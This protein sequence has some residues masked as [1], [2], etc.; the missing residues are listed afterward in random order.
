MT[1]KPN[2]H[3]E[4]FEKLGPD[5]RVQWEITQ[6]ESYRRDFWIIVIF[7][8]VVLLL[9]ALSLLAPNSFWKANEL[10]LRIPPQ[11]LFV[12]MMAMVVLALYFLRRETESRKLRLANLKRTIEHNTA[13]TA[14]LL[15]SLTNVF[16]RN[17]LYELLQGEIARAE[18]NQRPLTLVMCDVNNFK[19][20]NDR[21]GHLMGDYVLAQIAAILKYCIRGSDYVVRYGGDEFLIIL[22]ET[23]EAGAR[24][25]VNRIREK[26]A[27][28][29]NQSR[30]G[31]MPISVSL[32]LSTHVA[33][34][35]AEKDLAEAD[36]RMYQSKQASRATEPL[37][38]AP[39]A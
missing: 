1:G 28:W 24:I 34:Y 21:Y 13:H 3:H 39:S 2:E 36:S 6:I 11:V 33:G 16:N 31:D 7:V 25:V 9:G 29:D 18:R 15:D 10:V 30:I 32:G 12:V 5:A 14:G 17:F 23:E 27:D 22:P 4:L 19:I 8:A 26:V 38:R 37:T 35:A 20:V